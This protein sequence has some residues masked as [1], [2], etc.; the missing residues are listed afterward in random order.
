[1]IRSALY[2]SAFIGLVPA[3]NILMWLSSERG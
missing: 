1:M 3:S 2:Y